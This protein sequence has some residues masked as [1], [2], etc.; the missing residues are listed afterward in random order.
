[1]EGVTAALFTF[2]NTASRISVLSFNA[3]IRNE[4]GDSVCHSPHS[5]RKEEGAFGVQMRNCSKRF[6]RERMR[7]MMIEMISVE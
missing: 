2:V 1:M 4:K 7:I 5:R 6:A 3:R